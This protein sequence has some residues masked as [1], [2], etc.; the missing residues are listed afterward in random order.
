MVNDY[1]RFEAEYEIHFAKVLPALLAKTE[2]ASLERITRKLT[3]VCERGPVPWPAGDEGGVSR[4]LVFK[5]IHELHAFA[6]CLRAGSVLGAFHHVRA[7][8][9]LRGVVH[10]VF[11]V[12]GPERAARIARFAEWPNA[13]PYLYQRRREIERDLAQRT[14]EAFDAAT[15]ATQH[16]ANPSAPELAAWTK[17]YG[18]DVEKKGKPKEW[19]GNSIAALLWQADTPGDLIHQYDTICNAAHVS[20]IAANFVDSSGLA[21]RGW[22]EG[23][24]ENAVLIAISQAGIIVE[25]LDRQ[26][27]GVF[28]PLIEPEL[29]RAYK[30]I[31]VLD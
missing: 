3:F 31:G 21:L 16:R 24:G 1:D 9:E 2:L 4:A 23:R 18:K 25:A 12:E 28:E 11:G 30:I 20:P 17:L 13:A 5:L 22:E 19:H 29:R 14:P 15:R 7:L 8:M 27:G 10:H 26:C 6:G